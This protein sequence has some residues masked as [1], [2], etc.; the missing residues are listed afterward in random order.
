MV[1][2]KLIA[3]MAFASVVGL[4]SCTSSEELLFS[5]EIHEASILSSVDENSRSAEEAIDLAYT[6]FSKNQSRSFSSCDW[7]Y[8]CLT[9]ETSEQM[10]RGAVSSDT[11]AYVVNRGDCDGF[12]IVSADRR[13]PDVLAFSEVGKFE[14]PQDSNNIVNALFVNNLDKYKQYKIKES[15]DGYDFSPSDGLFD[16]MI[17]LCYQKEW[18]WDQN[19]AT[20]AHI[21]REEYP[22]CPVGCVGVA[23][24]LVITYCSTSPITIN[25]RKYYPHKFRNGMIYGKDERPG[26]QYPDPIFPGGKPLWLPVEEEDPDF[27]DYEAMYKPIALHRIAEFLF[28][29]GK[30]LRLTYDTEGTSGKTLNAIDYLIKQGF[31]ISRYEPFDLN[32]MTDYLESG[33]IIYA[34]AKTYIYDEQQ[35]FGHAWVI[36]GCCFDYNTDGSGDKENIFLHCNWGESVHMAGFYRGDVLR[37]DYT[38]YYNYRDLRY[39]AVQVK[40]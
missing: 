31:E 29:L 5:P 28:D 2:R 40:Q 22:G 25:G 34:D 4:C 23:T 1:A 39:F 3:G 13:L 11:L 32:K 16:K 38:G 37:I 26:I 35:K 33:Q 8:D 20:Y 7:S 27:S 9:S 12:I 6:F 36:D 30:D 21:V 18:H 24:G 15:V 17:Q 19:D 14:I 10:S